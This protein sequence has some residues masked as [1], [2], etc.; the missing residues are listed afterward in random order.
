[1]TTSSNKKLLIEV[2]TGYVE[3]QQNSS[4]FVPLTLSENKSPEEAFIHFHRKLFKVYVSEN[5][6][7]IVKHKN[8]K[9]IKHSG[10]CWVYG[11]KKTLI[12]KAK[13]RFS[14]NETVVSDFR[15]DLIMYSLGVVDGSEWSFQN[16]LGK[17]SLFSL[18]SEGFEV[19]QFVL[20]QY[21]LLAQLCVL[22]PKTDLYKEIKRQ[23]I[24]TS[25]N[26][27]IIKLLETEYEIYK[28]E[29][30]KQ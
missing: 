18:I 8:C 14:N 30:E 3:D 17:S 25:F 27:E 24:N 1:M 22:S 20:V 7:L 11:V 9:G 26:N 21:E 16:S 23:L 6:P 19:S 4:M 13:S 15:D 12:V 10:N 28:K 2:K 5:G 29:K